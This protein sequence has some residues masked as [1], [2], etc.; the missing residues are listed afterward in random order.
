MT[1]VSMT[2]NR[3]DRRQVGGYDGNKVS[4]IFIYYKKKLNIFVYTNRNLKFRILLNNSNLT[5]TAILE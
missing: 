4:Y 3:K 5:Y 2:T 1:L